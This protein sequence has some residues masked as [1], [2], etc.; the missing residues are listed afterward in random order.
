MKITVEL[1]LS[2]RIM[3]KYR[4]ITCQKDVKN[5]IFERIRQNISYF[6]IGNIFTSFQV[7]AHIEKDDDQIY[8]PNELYLYIRA[9]VHLFKF[10]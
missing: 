7:L 10:D 2:K 3:A 6:V 1:I 8:L 9:F 4:M 5:P